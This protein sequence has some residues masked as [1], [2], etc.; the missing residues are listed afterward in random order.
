MHPGLGC[1]ALHAFEATA[2]RQLIAIEL[3][4]NPQR[5]LSIPESALRPTAD[6]QFTV[7]VDAEGRAEIVEIQIGR[8]VPGFVE[9]LSGLSENDRIVIDGASK[10][11]PGG[12]VREVV[13]RSEPTTDSAGS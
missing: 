10:V 7:R 8:R 2:D 12:T 9:V 11:R 13:G 4:A 6:K 1:S 3:R 5:S